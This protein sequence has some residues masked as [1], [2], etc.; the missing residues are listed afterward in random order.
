MRRR[1]RS[2][3]RHHRVMR[4]PG[5]AV[6]RRRL[7]RQRFGVGHRGHAQGGDHSVRR[8]P[9]SRRLVRH[10]RC[11]GQRST[12]P[13]AEHRQG[14]RPRRGARR[15]RPRTQGA[16]A[17]ARRRPS[18]GIMNVLPGPIRQIGYVVGDIDEAI[19]SWV[20]LD[21][22]PW[23][24]VRGLSMRAHYRG[25]PCETTLSLALSNT[26]E[27]Q[28]ELIYQH[29]ETPSIFTEFLTAN[30]PGYHQLAYWA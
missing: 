12:R 10:T 4:V 17:A 15:D 27:M 5:P 21:V 24:A 11:G 26:G 2:A 20:A 6:R 14:D 30:G 28:I 3:R 19:A 13:V 29:D 1:T 22:G 23:F 7:A 25:R 18:H 16:G 9:A 8:W